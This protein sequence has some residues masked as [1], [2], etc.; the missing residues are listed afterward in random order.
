MMQAGMFVTASA[1]TSRTFGAVYTHWAREEDV[2][3]VHG[4]LDEELARMSGIIDVITSGDLL[5]SNESFSSTNES[6]GS[7]IAEQVTRALLRTGVHVRLVTHL[8][9]LASALPDADPAGAIFLR[10]P[11][12]SEDGRTYR[13]EEGPP[14]PTSWGLDLFD[15]TFGTHLA[16]ARPPTGTPSG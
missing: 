1:F 2:D 13:L 14:L 16:T 5:L 6:E 11:R 12:K 7:E 8:Y 15:E 3:L 10:A 4:K 9:D